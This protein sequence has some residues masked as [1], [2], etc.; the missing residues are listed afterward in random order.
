M[1]YTF[2]GDIH[3]AADD[4]AVLLAEPTLQASQV[5]F[6]GDY[7]DGMP[8]GEL[9]PLKVLDLIMAQVKNH[10]AVALL[11]NHDD[12]WAQTALG[13]ELAFDTWKRNGGRATWKLL[14]LQGETLPAISQQLNQPPLLAYTKFLQQ[15][16]VTW[17]NEHILAVHAGI[18]WGTAVKQQVKDDLIWIRDSYFFDDP[19]NPTNWHRNDLGKVIVTG[20]TPVQTLT[21]TKQGYVKMQ[22]DPAD[23][24]RYNIDSGSR[25]GAANGGIFAL[26]LATD[27]Q[28]VSRHWVVGGQ[29]QAVE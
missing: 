18:Y 27:G 15:L 13:N 17:E 23:T 6:L 8:V 24:P 10:A 21:T 28:V 9:A 19:A 11:G 25:S 26:T 12:F 5:I 7:L 14:G 22:A 4:L 3:S 2:I 20:H 29:L 16:P 1:N